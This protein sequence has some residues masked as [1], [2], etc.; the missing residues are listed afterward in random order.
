ML[1]EE[2][3]VEDIK[4]KLSRKREDE[5]NIKLS[6]NERLRKRDIRKHKTI[7]KRER[8]IEF[9]FISNK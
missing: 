9:G 2:E 3:V 1:K 8:Q 6:R 7:A 4:L 5:V